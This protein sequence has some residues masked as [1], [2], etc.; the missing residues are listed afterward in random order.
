MRV[1]EKYMNSMQTASGKTFSKP[2]GYSS[3]SGARLQ[4]T[5]PPE[6]DKNGVALD[7]PSP[8]QVKFSME[9]YDEMMENINPYAQP[10]I[11]TGK[12]NGRPLFNA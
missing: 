1:N 11:I 4:S 9:A 8:S 7:D 3:R 10:V 5:P 2:F 12:G 6:P